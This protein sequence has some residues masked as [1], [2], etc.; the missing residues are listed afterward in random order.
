MN[1]IL[2]SYV[3]NISVYFTILIRNTFLS[4]LFN[5]KHHF[6]LYCY[7]SKANHKPARKFSFR[8]IHSTIR[9]TLKSNYNT[10]AEN[11]SKLKKSQLDKN[12][13]ISVNL[14]ETKTC[15]NKNPSNLETNNLIQTIENNDLNHFIN[16][17]L[18]LKQKEAKRELE[19]KKKIS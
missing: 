11:N 2:F 3:I 13:K 1:K 8:N 15:N 10:E 5:K 12:N 7:C 18:V 14:N 6:L 17:A 4:G 19:E 9:Q 16:E